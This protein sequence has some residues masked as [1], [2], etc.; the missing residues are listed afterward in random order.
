MAFQGPQGGYLHFELFCGDYQHIAR[1]FSGFCWF[2]ISPAINFRLYLV[3][4]AS[5]DKKALVNVF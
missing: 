1:G 4:L 3:A 2:W 5:R